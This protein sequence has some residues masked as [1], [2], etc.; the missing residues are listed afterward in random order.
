[1]KG[2]EFVSSLNVILTWITRLVYVNVLWI[3]YSFLGLIIGG[4]FPATIATLSVFR[5][6][7]MG[8]EN[9]SIWN[10]FNQKYRKEFLGSNILGWILTG[11][12]IILY[13]NYRIMI[14]LEGDIFI[15]I[16]FAFYILLF[17]YLTLI[18]WSF[19]LI[20]HYKG[21]NKQHLKNAIII[22]FAKIHYTIAIML[23]LITVVYLSLEYPGIMP[24]FSVS[25]GALG[26]TWISLKTFN[27]MDESSTIRLHAISS[28][29]SRKNY[30]K[31]TN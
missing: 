2:N 4:V 19:P 23:I 24:F 10:T 12:G 6:W 1:M 26:W 16:P 15:Y 20:S 8:D 17:F 13:L 14:N 28:I 31:Q 3:L 21:S 27:R 11:I 5:K 25:L 18:I 29:K 9:I 22:G 7:L 30:F